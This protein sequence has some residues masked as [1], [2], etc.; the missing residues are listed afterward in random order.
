[1]EIAEKIKDMLLP[2]LEAIKKESQFIHKRLDSMESVLLDQSRRIDETNRRIDETNKRIDETNKRIDDTN[3]KID[4]IHDDLLSKIDETN[5]KID[6]IH[7]DLIARNDKLNA[8]M[9]K[10]AFSMVRQTEYSKLEE[11]IEKLQ[12]ELIELKSKVA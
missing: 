9:D 11:K 6:Y 5:N 10:I 1:M 4:K 8:R 2:E 12:A 7:R 3:K